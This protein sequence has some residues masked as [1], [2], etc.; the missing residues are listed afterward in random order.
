[1][2][3]IAG[4][5]AVTWGKVNGIYRKILQIAA[6]KDLLI[7]YIDDWEIIAKG[8]G[9]YYQIKYA[10]SI[11]RKFDNSRLEELI[12][13]LE[14]EPL[15]KGISY[16]LKEFLSG[17]RVFERISAR[18]EAYYNRITGDSFVYGGFSKADKIK[19]LVGRYT[20]YFEMLKQ[21]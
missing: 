6:G 7:E 16:C 21:A 5:G 15:E 19:Y 10:R 18:T 20:P 1:M 14:F 13:K 9:K 11:N 3:N 4:A 8:L 2:V 17:D 12:G